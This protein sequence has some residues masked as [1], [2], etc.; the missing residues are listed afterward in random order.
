MRI[1]LSLGL[2]VLI[3]LS[4]LVGGVDAISI[5]GGASGIIIAGPPVYEY[6][7]GETLSVEI[8]FPIDGATYYVNTLDLNVSVSA[9]AYCQYRINSNAWNNYS[10]P[11]QN[12]TLPAGSVKLTVSC[13]D[14]G[15]SGEDAARINVYTQGG[16]MRMSGSMWVLVIV[17][18]FMF[19]DDE[20]EKEEDG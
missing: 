5:N 4:N 16:G 14:A 11:S 10:I 3:L 7:G 18:V 19:M 15:V 9:S 6:G 12:V 20:D 17:L 1:G 13:V 2:T 8:T